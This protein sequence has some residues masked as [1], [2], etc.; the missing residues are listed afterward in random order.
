MLFSVIQILSLFLSLLGNPGFMCIAYKKFSIAEIAKKARLNAEYQVK[1]DVIGFQP[2]N[3]FVE[4]IDSISA[5]YFSMYEFYTIKN[6]E[7]I[8]YLND[9]TNYILNVKYVIKTFSELTNDYAVLRGNHDLELGF[10]IKYEKTADPSIRLNHEFE[11]TLW[12]NSYIEAPKGNLYPSEI[13]LER[14]FGTYKD[15]IKILNNNYPNLE[16]KILEKAKKYSK[17]DFDDN[18]LDQFPEIKR[19]Y[20]IRIWILRENAKCEIQQVY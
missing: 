10:V 15:S 20:M 18:F 4:P 7:N 14:V 5:N 3:I 9:T 8:T 13:V 16:D 17:L 6:I 11:D 19:V 1:F 12:V 2:V